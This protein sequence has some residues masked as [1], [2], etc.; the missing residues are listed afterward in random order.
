MTLWYTA[1]AIITTVLAFGCALH[2]LLNVRDPSSALGWI[3]LCLLVPILGPVLYV[4]F[5]INRVHTRARRLG[6]TERHL[7]AVGESPAL[8][9]NVPASLRQ[10]ATLTGSLQRW[11]LTM[12]NAVSALHD[13]DQAYPA[14]LEAIS[15]AR[16]RV[17]LSSYIFNSDAV[18]RRF[19]DALAQAKARGADV[20]VLV[21]GVGEYYSWPR[22]S[23]LLR[24]RGVRV[25]RFGPPSLIPPSLQL[26]L[27]NH[28]KIL[29]VDGKVGFAGGMNISAGNLA[30]TD[31]AG[32]TIR[33]IHFRFAG[34]VV[35]QLDTAFFEDWEIATRE[36]PPPDLEQVSGDGDSLCRV[37]TDGPGRDLFKLAAIYIGAVSLARRRITIVTPYF[38]PPRPLTG[39][40]VAAALRGVEVTV[41]L[42][43]RNN[44]P[45]AHWATRNMLWELL[46]WGVKCY[47]Q[48]GPFPHTKLFLVDHKYAVIGSAN[49][50]PRSLRLNFEL[51]IEIFEP[52]LTQQLSAH[53]DELRSRSREIT[54]DELN[55][56]SLPVLIRDSIAWLFTP[57]L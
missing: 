27:R 31:D 48:P 19:V 4:L 33:D 53:C 51:G 24:K 5:G 50:D 45:V 26:N 38:L 18:G 47:Y 6:L 46:R 49:M 20:R 13:G 55:D 37:V 34:P 16:Q 43:A 2:A 11:P 44:Q 23:R 25:A 17:C 28:R 40:L 29:S 9:D 8:P 52:D 57:Y 22:I 21:D 54:L 3:A 14:M 35:T 36:P 7:P 56:R 15:E 1:I 10:Q 32:H 42:P 12:N 30:A 39:A 41:I